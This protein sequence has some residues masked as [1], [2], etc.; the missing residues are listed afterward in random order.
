MTSARIVLGS[1]TE[2]G[3]KIRTF[4][5]TFPR[6]ILAELNTHRVFSRNSASS[7]AIPVKRM[8]ESLTGDIDKLFVRFGTNQSGMQA[9]ERQVSE[10]GMKI[11]Q[12]NYENLKRVAVDSVLDSIEETNVAKEVANRFIEP[13]MHTTA[14][15]TTTELNN[16]FFQRCDPN[17][18]P[19]FQSLAYKMLEAELNYDYGQHVLSH[20]QWHLPFVTDEEKDNYTLDNQKIIS[21]A[22]CA[23]ASYVKQNEIKSFDDLNVTYHRMLNGGHWSPFEHPATPMIKSAK[24]N[25]SGNF[26]GWY[27]LRKDFMKENKERTM[28]REDLEKLLKSKPSWVK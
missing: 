10:G 8:I 5:L 18:Q 13:F 27:Q 2:W 19:E 21:V 1:T 25:F 6:F 9:N 23:A 7:R 4:E 22:R 15:V 3:S 17:A 20:S 16:F 24:D 28:T 26:R 11:L 12:K 14:V